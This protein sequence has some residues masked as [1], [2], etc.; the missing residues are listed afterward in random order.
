MEREEESFPPQD[1]CGSG[2]FHFDVRKDRARNF[3]ILANKSR[4]SH[5]SGFL[6]SH[7]SVASFLA[8]LTFSNFSLRHHNSNNSLLPLAL[9][10]IENR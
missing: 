5:V 7:G 3:A 6:I 9:N 10:P 8:R 2:H 4:N 1:R